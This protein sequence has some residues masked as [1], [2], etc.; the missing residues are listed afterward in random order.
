MGPFPVS[1]VINP[2]AVRLRLPRSMR[3]HPTFHISKIKPVKES[4]LVPLSKPPPPPQFIDGGPVYSVRKLLAIRRRG[5]GC[6][7]LV[8]WEGY[9][10]EERSWVSSGNILDPELIRQFHDSHPEEPGPSGA[11]R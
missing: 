4:P 9:S 1:K 7:Y 3:I 2:V 10:P 5:R 6:Q 11:G 8:D